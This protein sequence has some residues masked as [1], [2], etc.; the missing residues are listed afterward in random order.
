MIDLGQDNRLLA[1]LP[2]REVLK[3]RIDGDKKQID[4]FDAEIKYKLGDAEVAELPGWRISLKEEQ[5][6]EYTVPASSRRVL[7][8]KQLKEKEQAA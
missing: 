7:R 4:A 1:I 5:R 8:V 2:E 3:D 6:R